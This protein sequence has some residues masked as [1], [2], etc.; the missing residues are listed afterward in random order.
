VAALSGSG[1][2][3]SVVVLVAAGLFT[4]AANYATVEGVR[5]AAAMPG[6]LRQLPGVVVY[7]ADPL[8]LDAPGVVAGV[9]GRDDERQHRYSGLRLLE[10]TG[11]TYFL[12]SDGWTREH[13]V[14]LTLK[15]DASVRL[16][17]TRGS[18]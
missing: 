8:H 15:H 12:V 4:A 5:L 18:P 9:V 2:R 1:G 14:I 7:S 16:E 6:Q 17:F 13:G 10:S 3:L 11:G